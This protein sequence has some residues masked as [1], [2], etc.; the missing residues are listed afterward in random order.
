[1]GPS[2]DPTGPPRRVRGC[3]ASW[4]DALASQALE[5]HEPEVSHPAGENLEAVHLAGLVAGETDDATLPE[6]EG[7]SVRRAEGHGR[8]RAMA[9][10][11]HRVVHPDVV[12]H[13][14]LVAVVRPGVVS[15]LGGRR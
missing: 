8:F 7:I 1:M 2:P 13:V 14:E 10:R 4:L 3:D 12:P 9:Q 5:A 6:V 11:E 15:E